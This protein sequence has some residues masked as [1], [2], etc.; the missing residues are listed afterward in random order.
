M[1]EGEEPTTHDRSHNRWSSWQQRLMGTVVVQ[2]VVMSVFKTTLSYRR[3]TSP[4][5]VLEFTRYLHVGPSGLPTTTRPLRPSEVKGHSTVSAD[6]CDMSTVTGVAAVA[7]GSLGG[8]RGRRQS[9]QPRPGRAAST[10]RRPLEGSLCKCRFFLLF[11]DWFRCQVPVLWLASQQG[12]SPHLETEPG[13]EIRHFY[14]TLQ[15]LSRKPRAL[16]SNA[17][18]LTS[19]R[20]KTDFCPDF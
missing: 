18:M 20:L 10:Q 2:S 17:D 13:G 3:D 14:L 12:I 7:A 9:R 6:Y 1:T 16:W 8:A 15:T 4:S 5:C 11:C 19:F